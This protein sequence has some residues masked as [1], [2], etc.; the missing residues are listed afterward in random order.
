MQQSDTINKY[1]EKR[2]DLT[3]RPLVSGPL[4]GIEQVVVIPALAEKAYLFDTLASLSANAPAELRR[5]LV[6]CVVNNRAE[7]YADPAD[8]DD[9]RQTLELLDTM[10]HGS[11]AEGLAPLRLAYVD[12]SSPGHELS[13][14]DGVG[15]AR[16]IGLDWGLAVLR[17]TNAL[18]G[19]LFSLDAD[20]SVAP[21]YLE[22]VRAHFE[23]QGTWAA[24][25]AY[26]HRLEGS[27]GEVAGIVRYELFLRYHA[28]GLA[29]AKS[30]YA[31]HAIGSTIVCRA[32]AYAVVSGMNRRQ[33]G[34]DFYF[35]QQ[36]IKTGRVH[37]IAATAVYPSCRASGRVPFGTGPRVRQF[38]E[39][40]Q[41]AYSLYHPESYRILKHW[42][43]VVA[44]HLEASSDDLLSRAEAVCPQ[45]SAFLEANCFER[46]WGRLKQHSAHARGLHEQFHRWFDGLKTL[47]LIHHL[48]DN[49]FPQ[50]DMFEAIGGLLAML[51]KGPPVNMSGDIQNDLG[52]QTDLLEYLRSCA[53]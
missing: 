30:P 5:T 41:V 9:N 20:T 44:N 11:R 47:R 10:L 6:L 48:R 12:A 16:K 37:S 15:L 33:A 45:L 17:Q 50:Q 46:T 29:Y 32:E 38:D 42:L 39:G 13:E 34:E 1:L 4:A 35:L 19:L 43:S 22:V 49:G 14:K 23:T 3:S 26:A 2:A 7:P 51:D 24:V 52:R 53:P 27:P 8:I 21:D 31:F 36:L 18:C 28:L 40:G 25:V